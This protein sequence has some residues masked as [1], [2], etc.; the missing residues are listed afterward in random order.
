MEKITNKINGNIPLLTAS[1]VLLS[2][3]FYMVALFFIK[4]L[5]F[6]YDVTSHVASQEELVAQGVI[7]TIGLIGEIAVNA[8]KL[9]FLHWKMMIVGGGIAFA[10]LAVDLLLNKNPEN[11]LCGK[12][13]KI[14]GYFLFLLLLAYLFIAFP[15]KSTVSGL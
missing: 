14:S 7:L 10:L 15:R 3:L 2:F 12:V 11:S 4:G 1:A 8:V 13:Q 5:G 6:G 9:F